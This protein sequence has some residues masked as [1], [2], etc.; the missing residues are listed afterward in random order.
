[1]DARF[2]LADKGSRIQEAKDLLAMFDTR[3]SE[4]ESK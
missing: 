3:S 2:S 1:V 4:S